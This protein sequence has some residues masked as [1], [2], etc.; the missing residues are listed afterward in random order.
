MFHLGFE[1]SAARDLLTFALRDSGFAVREF[2]LSPPQIG[3][4]NS[5]LRY[6]LLA[7]RIG[8]VDEPMPRSKAFD[9][10]PNRQGLILTDF[11]SP[12]GTEW[13]PRRRKLSEYLE[14]D[15][16]DEDKRDLESYMVGDAVLQKHAEVIS[17]ISWW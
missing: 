6:Y 7:R 17:C 5:R 10:L 3:V 11:P 9:A 1:H 13:Q 8:T 14:K 4:P 2:L 15:P 12:E 16:S